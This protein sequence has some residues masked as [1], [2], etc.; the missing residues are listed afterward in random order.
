MK[1][2]LLTVVFL[3]TFVLSNAQNPLAKGQFQ[4]NAGT[5][6]S[7]WGVPVYAGLEFGIHK[8]VSIG[9]ETSFRK[10]YDDYY[11]SNEKYRYNH[12]A[13]AIG[14]F[15][16]YHFN[17]LLKIPKKYDFYAG[18]NAT[19]LAW[20]TDAQYYGN[21]GVYSNDWKNRYNDRSSVELGVQ[22]GARYF[23]TDHFGLNAEIGSGA[24]FGAKFGIT[25]K[26]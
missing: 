22:V 21:K 9:V 25:Y 2:S 20:N 17:S 18:A 13:F 3:L 26:F 19:Y 8:D 16:N 7:G 1:K 11:Y 4:L 15:G 23:F 24:I 6:F 5:G 14:T 10:Y 12:S